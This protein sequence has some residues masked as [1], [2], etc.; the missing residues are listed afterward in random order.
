MKPGY[1]DGL[2]FGLLGWSVGIEWHSF[3]GLIFDR[4]SKQ[5]DILAR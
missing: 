3:I 4:L 1:F 2:I 5:P